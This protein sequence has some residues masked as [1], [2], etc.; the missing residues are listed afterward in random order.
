MNLCEESKNFNIYSFTPQANI[1]EKKKRKIKTELLYFYMSP[2]NFLAS[3]H[4]RGTFELK[5]YI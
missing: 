2:M 4:S 5:P 1:D 3:V